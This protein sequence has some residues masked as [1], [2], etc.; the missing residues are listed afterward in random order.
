[1]MS[2]LW[3]E[4]TIGVLDAMVIMDVRRK[5]TSIGDSNKAVAANAPKGKAPDASKLRNPRQELADSWDFFQEVQAI[6][7][8]L[9]P[10]L[11]EAGELD[12][13]DVGGAGAEAGA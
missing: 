11:A 9:S 7:A 1:M 12:A 13:D 3:R 8:F 5:L 2:P 10:E 4:H 6:G